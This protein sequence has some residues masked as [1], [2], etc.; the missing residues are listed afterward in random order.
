MLSMRKAW[1]LHPDSL[2]LAATH[3]EVDVGRPRAGSLVMRYSVTGKM[4]DLHMPPVTAAPRTDELWQHTCFEAF[5]R[6]SPGAGYYEVNFAPSAQWA[7]YRFNGYRTGMRVWTQVT[8][9]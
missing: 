4:S 5:V 7:A 8:G 1:K 9:P 6:T 2:C 3:I